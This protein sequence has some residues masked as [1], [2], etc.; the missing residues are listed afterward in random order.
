MPAACIQAAG[1]SVRMVAVCAVAEPQQA[2]GETRWQ[3]PVGDALRVSALSTANAVATAADAMRQP[4][5]LLTIPCALLSSCRWH[6]TVKQPW[7]TACL[8]CGECQP[9]V[10]AGHP[11]TTSL[12]GVLRLRRVRAA[13]PHIGALLQGAAEL[14][15]MLSAA[16]SGIMGISVAVVELKRGALA[17]A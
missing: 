16:S 14:A 10:Q 13:G 3:H 5:C 17:L 15:L 11:R 1:S 2:G 4:A 7:G 6:Y 9:P 8:D 12:S